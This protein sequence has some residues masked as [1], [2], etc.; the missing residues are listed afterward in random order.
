MSAFELLQAEV[1]AQMDLMDT[2]SQTM[3]TLLQGN[4]Q[5]KDR[6]LKKFGHHR[7]EI[8]RLFAASTALFERA[9]DQQISDDERAEYFRGAKEHHKTILRLQSAVIEQIPK[10][11]AEN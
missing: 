4:S 1:W 10:W 6:A 7:S 9:G 2:Q 3:R 11:I 5:L 8:T